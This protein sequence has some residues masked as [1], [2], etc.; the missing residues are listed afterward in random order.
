M[1]AGA[2]L[3]DGV[4]LADVLVLLFPGKSE[5][6]RCTNSAGVLVCMSDCF[7][8][9]SDVDSRPAL[10]LHLVCLLCL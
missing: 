9:S 6:R 7:D 1:F 5:A 10:L 4:T 8:V 3:E 2:G